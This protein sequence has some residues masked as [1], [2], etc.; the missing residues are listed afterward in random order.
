MKNLKAIIAV[1]FFCGIS[2]QGFSQNGNTDKNTPQPNPNL[3]SLKVHELKLRSLG[4]S[5]VDGVTQTRRILALKKFIPYLVKTLEIPGSYDYPFDSLS[6]LKILQPEDKTFRLLNW[7]LKYNDGTY[8]YFGAIQM[9]SE[10]KLKLIPLRDY[11]DSVDEA[12][13]DSMICTPQQWLGAVYYKIIPTKIKDKMYYTLLGWDG[14]TYA[15]DKKLVEVLSFNEE[16]KPEF[17]APIF[18]VKG[19]TKSRIIFYYAG[20]S[21]MILNYVEEHNLITFDH[22]VPPNPNSKGVLYTYV[23]DGTY[24]YL[25]FKKGKWVWKEG[26]FENFKKPIKEAD[27]Q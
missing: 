8:R 19:K 6:F 21:T 5:V 20:N 3:D 18:N 15:S 10:D 13:M 27:H 26:L 1:C 16:G 24:D 9:K 4:D 12:D 25:E 17:G 11:R 2:L 14:Y 7:A 22:L 23:P